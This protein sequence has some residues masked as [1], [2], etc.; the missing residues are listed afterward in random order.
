MVLPD[1]RAGRHGR[2]IASGREVGSIA[3]HGTPRSV[4]ASMGGAGP[5]RKGTPKG[6]QEHSPGSVRRRRAPPWVTQ[7]GTTF[8][9]EGVAQDDVCRVSWL[10]QVPRPSAHGRAS[11][12]RGPMPEGCPMRARCG[13]VTGF[14]LLT[15]D[16]N[17]GWRL[18]ESGVNRGYSLCNYALGATRRS[19]IMVPCMTILGIVGLFLSA[20]FEM[21]RHSSDGLRR[22][23]FGRSCPRSALSTTASCM[24][25]KRW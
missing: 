3:R 8:N 10:W 14:A 17:P 15:I 20:L 22:I 18:D 5:Y 25:T 16:L 6:V 11:P 19:A 1:G 21:P 2:T 12:E 9:P 7:R 23:S 13:T 24:G 4:G